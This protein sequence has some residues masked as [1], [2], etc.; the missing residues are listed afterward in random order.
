LIEDFAT[1]DFETYYDKEY[2]LKKLQTDAYVLDDRFEIIGASIKANRDSEPIWFS[3]EERHMKEFLQ[4]SIDWATTPV[5]AQHAHFDG[6]ICTQRLGLKPKM[7]LDTLSMSRM[8]YP[9]L[10]SHSLEHMA[11]FFGIG[12]KGSQVENYMGYRRD[13]FTAEE[14]AD[15]G[16]YC[17]NDTALTHTIAELLLDATPLLELFLI[18]MT[19][20]MFTEPH[21]VGDTERFKA[22]YVS[23]IER[24]EAL[25]ASS[26]VTKDILMSNQKF[27]D[28]LS[29]R[30]V[31]PPTKVSPTT[32]RTT[33]AFARTD[34]EFT[35]LL[36][37]HEERVRKLVEARLG[38]KSS[39]AETRALRFV[40]T[41][42]R[43]A[44]PVYL[45][46]WG[47][48]TT[49]RLSGGNKMNWQNLPAR[50]DAK[51]IRNCIRAPDGYKV[52]VG[53]SSNI[54]LRFAMVAAGQVD[55]VA[56]IR[57][58]D[59][60][61]DKAESDMYCDFS[62]K[63]HGRVITNTEADYKERFIGKVAMLSLQYS[64]AHMTFMSM[65]RTIAGIIVTENEAKRIVN[66]Y[67]R[68]FEKLPEIWK[69]CNGTVLNAIH[70]NDKLISVDVNGWFLT[71]EDGFAMPGHIGVVYKKLRKSMEG[72][73]IYNMGRTSTKIYGGKVFENLCQH[74]A[75]HV[76]MWQTAKIHRKYPVALSV[77]DE[78]VCVVPEDDAE[79]CKDYMS[80]V[81]RTAPRWCRDELPLNCEVAIGDSYG[82]A[83]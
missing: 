55:A 83:K 63:L 20:R 43:G 35:D 3:G 70:N 67:R 12:L 66:L 10:V 82:E 69:Y 53:D 8:H 31:I 23:E 72:D 26:G 78:V 60:L 48:K 57:H 1:I 36:Y 38:V 27:A 71:T 59:A 79:D 29:V 32:G 54:E 61:G 28:A 47:A 19:I 42:K 80:E 9:F 41:S 15:Y 16:G 58:Y 44:M 40:E 14:L 52:V 17:D 18:D 39:I 46:H 73:W 64:S 50:G 81:L 34:E 25:V 65:L 68:T 21:L 24:K 76:V 62:T 11:E 4:D 51:E 77:H 22:Y 37:H 6:F 33:L 75:R 30:G 2:T 7:W 49:G 74:G 5:C 56:Q 13:D 45:S